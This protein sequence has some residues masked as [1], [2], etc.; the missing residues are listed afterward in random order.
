MPISADLCGRL[1]TKVANP[2]RDTDIYAK[3]AIR[4]SARSR[5]R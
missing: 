2:V 1:E 4:C 5:S 3:A